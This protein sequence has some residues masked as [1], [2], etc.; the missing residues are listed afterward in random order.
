MTLTEA[1]YWFKRF[2]VVIGA[3]FGI[4]IIILLII[5]YAPKDVAPPEY[6]NANY[7]CTD[8]KEDFLSEQLS[9]P[10]LK[11]GPDSELIFQIETNTGQIESLPKI[12]NVYE[13]DN[14]GQSLNSQLQATGIANDLGFNPDGIIRKDENTYAWLDVARNRN[15]EIDA[16]T[17]NLT[18]TTSSDYIRKISSESTLPSTSEAATLAAN[19]LR[20][21][22]I[23]DD[24]YMSNS[25]VKDFYY[26]DINPDGSYSEAQSPGEADL[27]RVDFKRRKSMISIG[28]NID[29]FEEIVT[30]LEKK[31]LDPDY[32]FT[33][34]QETVVYNQEKIQMFNFST[35]V[36]HNSPVKSNISVYVGAEDK[37]FD[38]VESIYR[39]E[40]SNW[41][42]KE[43]PCGT[44]EL[45]SPADA[46]QKIQNGEGSLVHLVSKSN[47]DRIRDHQIKTVKKFIVYDITLAYY[48][49]SEESKFLQPIYVVTG[50]A[51]LNNDEKADFIFYIPAINYDL[52]KD[53]QVPETTTEQQEENILKF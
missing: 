43:F 44:Y 13:F 53:A 30:S 40:Y 52:V 32:I 45:I 15:L 26:I 23:L 35:L 39:I 36:L 31:M 34:E 50:D 2:G 3:F 5:F 24:D 33:K 21:A 27:I 20:Q 28:E 29:G 9:I 1:A 42:I 6:L 19:V 51:Y 16:R 37:E 18:M 46:I 48:E 12:I 22:N 49:P 25:S 4:V 7:T 8:L 38:T 14:R 17:L 41:P 10:Q 47:L 11:M